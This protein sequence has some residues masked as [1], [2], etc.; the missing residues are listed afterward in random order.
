MIRINSFF[1]GGFECADH[2]NRSGDRI[3]LLKETRHDQ[4]V[5]EDYQLLKEV[6]IR[7]VREGICWSDVEKTPYTYD[8]SEVKVRIKAAEAMG[9]QQIWDLCHFGYPDDL[10]PT[11]PRFTERFVLLCKSFSAFYRGISRQRLFIVPI[12]EISFLS[13]H[14]GDVRGTVPFAIHSG[15]DI[16]YHLCKAAIKGIEA[17][18]EADPDTQILLVEPMIHIHPNVDGVYEEAW[19]ANEDQYQAMDIIMGRM[20]PELGGSSRHADLMGFN[21]YYNCQW[22][23]RGPQLPWPELEQDNAR[24]MPLSSLLKKGFERYGKPVVLSETGHFNE[25]RGQWIREIS[26]ECLKALAMGIDLRGICI[27]PVIERP[28]WDDLNDLHKAGLWDMDEFKNRIPH[29]DSLL[30]LRRSIEKFSKVIHQSQNPDMDLVTAR[31]KEG[32]LKRL[33]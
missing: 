33:M 24:R 21:Y 32:F 10:I 1:W 2:I 9:I 12:N 18:K 19:R 25:K 23:H 27:Y 11:H 26:D 3:N 20:C 7:T 29:E 16:K 4:R 6:G 31:Q 14:S 8:F 28:D 30:A 22:I 15:F 13:W 17:L 5:R